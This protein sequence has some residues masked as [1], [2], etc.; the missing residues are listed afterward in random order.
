MPDKKFRPLP[1]LSTEQL[2]RFSSR[3]KEST[4]DNCWPWI[5]MKDDDGYGEF[6]VNNRIYRAHRLSYMIHSGTDPGPLFVCHTCDRPECVNPHHLF[7]GT[8]TENAADRTSKQREARG[9][10]HGSHTHPERFRRGE[11]HYRC[12]LSDADVA[13]IRKEYATGLG[14]HSEIA[15][16]YGVCRSSVSYILAGKTRKTA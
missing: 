4:I 8:A 5:G 6:K 1:K 10:Q 16:R 2:N 12:K 3:T 11:A 9:H 15:K 7:P 14:T 13:A